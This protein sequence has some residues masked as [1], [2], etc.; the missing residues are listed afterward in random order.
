MKPSRS[1]LLRAFIAGIAGAALFNAI[2]VL[3]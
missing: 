3:W 1:L 2:K